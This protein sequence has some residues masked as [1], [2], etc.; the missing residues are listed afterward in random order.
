MPEVGYKH[1][2]LSDDYF[3][4]LNYTR[5]PR[6]YEGKSIPERDVSLHS[7]FLRRSLNQAW[8][9]ALRTAEQ[10]KAVALPTRTGIYLEFRSDPGIDLVTKSLEDRKQG[11]R[12]LSV[13]DRQIEGEDEPATFATVF[14]PANKQG[15]FLRK[16]EKYQNEQTRKGKPKNRP[17]IDSIADIRLAIL[18]SFW[19]DTAAMPD[20]E[21]AWCEAWIRVE[22]GQ[23]MDAEGRFRGLLRE[24]DIEASEGALE[25]PERT[26]IQIFANGE[27]LANLL[28]ASDEIAEFRLAKETAAFWL[29][30]PNVDQAQA[31]QDLLERLDV[32][33][34]GVVVCLLDTG[35]NNGHPLIQPVLNND[36]CHS[37]ESAWGVDDHD[38]HGTLM[39]GVSAFGDLQDI[40]AS[41]R[42]VRVTHRLESAKILPRFGQNPHDLYGFVTAQGISRAEIQAPDRRRII[43]MAVSSTDDRDRGRPS[44]WSGEID[45]LASGAEDDNRRLII[46]AAGNTIHPDEWQNYPNA[47]LTNE[48]HDPGQAWNALTVGAWTQKTVI[49]DPAFADYM[50]V[51]PAGSISPFTSTSLTWEQKWPVKPDL[52]MEGGNAA[53]D[54]N[55]DCSDLDDL[56]LV[57]THYQPISRLFSGHNMTSAATALAARM[58]ARL[59][60]AYPEAWPETIRALMVHSAE[61]TPAM[62]ERFLDD[63]SKISYGKLLRICGYGVPNL[64]RALRCATNSL[65]LVAE[66]E[67][68]PYDKEGNNF[69]T[70]DM[71]IH[72]LPWPQGVLLGL[73]EAQIMMR[74]TLSYFIEPGPGQIGW[75][76]RYRYASHGLRFEVNSPGES[77]DELLIRI[78]KAAREEGESPETTS[79]SERWKIGATARDHGSIHSDIWFGNAATIAGSNLIGVYPVGGWW[80]ERTHL[81]R[82]NWRTRYSLIVSLHTAEQNVDIYTPVATQVGI[83]TPV[84]IEIG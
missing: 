14:V 29:D 31:V 3:D 69:K 25:F 37:V 74:V 49:Q 30:L 26:V 9:Q 1:I 82:W 18:S 64:E 51:A 40:L 21:A 75:R 80:R 5:P 17:L 15:H 43:C 53:A 76:D 13:A 79:A 67:L 47:T 23:A 44:S 58:A 73:G 56:S 36:D 65:T 63:E 57:S 78:N 28:E 4:R 8:E 66:R 38:R 61:W 55:G 27:Q 2:F 24:F 22:A 32:V 54:T 45:K 50:P 68:Q 11:I 70:R 71:H 77:R 19:Q 62:R 20:E 46:L 83:V 60:A 10:R 39:A 41:G 52:L 6:R 84:E 12:L 16:V 7:R 42:R 48:V 72:E 81:G 34:T 33:D 59:Q 35:V